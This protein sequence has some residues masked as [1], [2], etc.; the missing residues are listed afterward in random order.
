MSKLQYK[1]RGNTPVNGKTRIYLSCHPEDV[2]H[3]REAIV[4][5]LLEQCDCAVYYY[6]DPADVVVDDAYRSTLEQMQLVLIPITRKLLTEPNKTIEID[7]PLVTDK[8]ISM[9]PILVEENLLTLYTA[10]FGSVQFL[11]RCQQDV[12]AVSYKEKL[13]FYLNA[14]TLADA[15][16]QQIREA[17]DSYIFLSYRKKD[18][19]YAQELMRLIHSIEGFAD[20]AIWYDEYL[21]PGEN[22][23]TIIQ[24]MLK[25][26]P[27]FA[28]AVTPLLLEDG[29]YIMRH[30]YPAAQ[31]LQKPILP[32]QMQPTDQQ[33]LQAYYKNL[34][35]CV[36]STDPESI[37]N[38]LQSC[39]RGV[40]LGANQDDPTH[41]YFMGLAYLN[42]VDV[43]VDRTRAVTY[44]QN[45]AFADLP[46]AVE[47]LA[48][49]YL[50]GQA[51]DCNQEKAN[52]WRCRLH[53]LLT[54]RMREK[55]LL[56][57]G[58]VPNL[59]NRTLTDEESHLVHWYLRNLQIVLENCESNEWA[60]AKL[61]FIS[62]KYGTLELPYLR[63]Y[64]PLCVAHNHE[65]Q[66]ILHLAKKLYSV[67]KTKENALFLA[68][69]SL[70][71]GKSLKIEEYVQSA[72]KLCRKLLKTH[73]DPKIKLILAEALMF[74]VPDPF[75]SSKEFTPQQVKYCW[76]AAELCH[77]LAENSTHFPTIRLL[78]DAVSYL[79]QKEETLSRQGVLMENAEKH[80]E[81]ILQFTDRI[82]D[83]M[84]LCHF[85]RSL[86]DY[87]SEKYGYDHE[88]TKIC[89]EKSRAF[90]DDQYSWGRSKRSSRLFQT[91]LTIAE[92]GERRFRGEP[93]ISWDD[94]AYSIFLYTEQFFSAQEELEILK[95]QIRSARGTEHYDIN[96]YLTKA[97]TL[98]NTKLCFGAGVL[99]AS[100][101]MEALEEESVYR[102]CGKALCALCEDLV[103]H[104]RMCN[105]LGQ[106]IPQLK[107]L[108][109]A[110]APIAKVSQYTP[111]GVYWCNTCHIAIS[112]LQALDALENQDL[113]KAW[114]CCWDALR[115]K[116][117]YVQDH[118]PMAC[119]K[120]ILAFLTTNATKSREYL[121]QAIHWRKDAPTNA[122]KITIAMNYSMIA[123]TFADDAAQALAPLEDAMR[124]SRWS[125]EEGNAI[126][127]WIHCAEQ[128]A[129]LL[130]ESA[131]Q[132]AKELRG[133]LQDDLRIYLQKNLDIELLRRY[134]KTAL[135]KDYFE[136][137][138][139]IFSVVLVQLDD[140]KEH[141]QLLS[142]AVYRTD[143][144]SIHRYIPLILRAQETLLAQE[145]TAKNR[146]HLA[147]T[148]LET[149]SLV[150]EAFS[151]NADAISLHRNRLLRAQKLL[152]EISEQTQEDLA[153][154]S[155]IAVELAALAPG[156]LPKEEKDRIY[157]TYM[158]TNFSRTQ[159]IE[160]L[161]V[162]L[163]ANMEWAYSTSAEKKSSFL[164]LLEKA[165]AFL[166]EDLDLGE[167]LSIH[168]ALQRS[169]QHG[170][171]KA[172]LRMGQE[173]LELYGQRALQ[174]C[175]TLTEETFG[176]WD[177]G[178]P[179]L[180]EKLVSIADR[181]YPHPPA[182]LTPDVLARRTQRFYTF[183][184]NIGECAKA[185][186]L[187]LRFLEM[188]P[189]ALPE[190][191]F[192]SFWT[193]RI[194]T[195][196]LAGYP[197]G[198]SAVI[199]KVLQMDRA[200]PQKHRAAN[201][202][203]PDAFAVMADTLQWYSRDYVFD[204]RLRDIFRPLQSVIEPLLDPTVTDPLLAKMRLQA[205]QRIEC[206]YTQKH[207]YQLMRRFYRQKD[208]YLLKDI[209][210]GRR[211]I[212]RHALERRSRMRK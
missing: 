1:T 135:H 107:P 141:L 10:I 153:L 106:P 68:Q 100:L 122:Q 76:E 150:S 116:P 181:L 158:D 74:F 67:D 193:E 139:A 104:W 134:V 23:N 56:V 62:Q 177:P 202:I 197:E 87:Y 88:S 157:E 60:K 65:T 180:K 170:Q 195:H 119:A 188:L 22:F 39:F 12:T 173:V 80:A 73:D 53:T 49:M 72:V 63:K 9:L 70:S 47:K 2:A 166:Q 127:I 19:K 154:L 184:Y 83:S 20:V 156:S 97:E 29:N 30:E 75:S 200:S 147:K 190:V 82:E 71:A 18:R 111:N 198:A 178:I 78:L 143:F 159:R 11:D 6:D 66:D 128:T 152:S 145:D 13:A 55:A 77:P 31:D 169:L 58:N 201:K 155:K 163:K 34:P 45:A 142:E 32:V 126:R 33:K 192:D 129:E 98:W 40:T 208:K 35:D 148:L 203:T 144:L 209:R 179:G 130:Q 42:G 211:K 105:W 120:E 51:L 136:D 59:C 84:R 160:Q 14:V 206:V 25:Q 110:A 5:D 162:E 138:A 48:D 112:C 86:G 124:Y 109:K 81:L 46:E 15:Q 199:R 64:L 26:S 108:E 90:C 54:H 140:R 96:K 57:N 38:N 186:A 172:L 16:I 115:F 91:Y 182:G 7:L 196:L 28:L 191:N 118:A 131:P 187:E 4:S 17:F 50:Y 117:E 85:Y 185:L 99:Q 167:A 44:I 101:Q 94:E 137:N 171:S 164:A 113:Q 95:R 146:R 37:K 194:R 43:E 36:A 207:C 183:Y 114:D 165:K 133:R 92:E 175:D 168:Q 123:D 132:R 8:R 41:I 174:L 27:V 149:Q 204:R 176:G 161:E 52:A 79:P 210:Q 205:Y 3:W 89:K 103:T 102:F 189:D 21:V 24:K 69:V 151:K 61:C 93:Q 212:I 125:L 121:T